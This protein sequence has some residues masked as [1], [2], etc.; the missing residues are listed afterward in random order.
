MADIFTKS[1][2]L[3]IFDITDFL[4]GQPIPKDFFISGVTGPWYFMPAAWEAP[5]WEDSYASRLAKRHFPMAYSIGFETAEEALEAAEA[6]EVEEE[7]RAAQ[8]QGFL[9]FLS[10][11]PNLREVRIR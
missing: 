6:W 10:G 1:G 4:P 8:E 3:R 2:K 9:D 7:K 11:A 5:Y